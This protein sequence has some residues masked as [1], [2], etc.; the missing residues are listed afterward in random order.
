MIG[1]TRIESLKEGAQNIVVGIAIQ[2][3]ANWI[4]L[5]W[6]GFVPSVGQLAG[7]AAIMTIIS[8]ARSYT[9]RRINERKKFRDLPTE[10]WE[11]FDRIKAERIRQV[12]I[13]GFDARHD[14][15]HDA[16][17]LAL[18]AA[19][20]ATHASFSGS[21]STTLLDRAATLWPWDRS[22]FKPSYPERD[23]EK[24]GAMLVAQLASLIRADKRHSARP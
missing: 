24:A 13:E 10:D 22:W 21:G 23:C 3:A 12:K 8:L 20:Y 5:P 16:G 4:V 15:Y 9:L 6:F 11:A 2:S 7:I 14:D 1:Q 17:E 18:G 19:A